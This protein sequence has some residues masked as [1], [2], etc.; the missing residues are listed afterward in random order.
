ML[1]TVAVHGLAGDVEGELVADLDAERLLE[2]GRQRDERL[3]GVGGRPPA[4]GDEAIVGAELGLPG[5]VLLA[6]REVL[7]AA[8]AARVL[9]RAAVDEREPAAN[10]R[11]HPGGA[12]ALSLEEVH[13]VPARR[14]G[15]VDEEI[16][17]Q[18]RRQRAL[19]VPVQ[20]TAQDAQQQQH[21][22]AGA[23]GDQLHDALG[24][25]AAQIGDAEAPGDADAAAQP[26]REVDQQAAGERQQ[27]DEG[28]EPGGEVQEQRMSRTTQ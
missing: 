1:A 20:V 16:V 5:Q 19:P 7:L 12:R 17:G 4:P 18:V 11:Q 8:S 3:A 23:E 26:P 10:H 14:G 24:A 13:E 2:L 6:G 27:Q 9:D 25:A 15:N 28:G 22:D 21:H